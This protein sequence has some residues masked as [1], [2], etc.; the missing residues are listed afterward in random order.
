MITRLGPPAHFTRSGDVCFCYVPQKWAHFTH[1]PNLTV[2]T[3]IYD[4]PLI[5]NRFLQKNAFSDDIL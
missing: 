5:V 4:M 3:I 1:Y 2:T